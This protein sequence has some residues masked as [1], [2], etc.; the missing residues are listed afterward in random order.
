[1]GEGL[2]ERVLK[3]DDMSRVGKQPIPVPDGVNVE[4]DGASVTVRGP[5]G[6]LSRQ[7]SPDIRITREDGQLFV[8]RPSD[9]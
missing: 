5:R 3:G 9:E 7:F 8:T 2:G 1:M 4:I 6:E